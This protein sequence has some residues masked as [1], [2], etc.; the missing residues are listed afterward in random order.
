M[1]FPNISARNYANIFS[2]EIIQSLKV[3]GSSSRLE[4]IDEQ[5]GTTFEWIWTD[6]DLKFVTW[7][8]ASDGGYWINGKPGSG[9]SRLM[10]YIYT[11]RSKW[12]KPPV[13]NLGRGRVCISFFFHNR[14]SHFQ[15]T[16]EGLLQSI[17]HQILVFEPR[18]V[19][20]IVP[21]HV[22]RTVPQK[23]GWQLLDLK[24]A[25]TQLLEQ[26]TLPIDI[27]LFVDAIDEYDGPPENIAGFIQS[28]I[29]SNYTHAMKIKICFSSRLLNTFIDRFHHYEGERH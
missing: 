13:S 24:H 14:G 7:L 19:K 21:I 1:T 28:I 23:G 12:D 3:E 15:K 10:K 11:T 17:L 29:A 25:F 26:D 9:K 16:F 6:T 5:Y 4:E 20:Q 22:W 18:L 8:E 27:S 2:K